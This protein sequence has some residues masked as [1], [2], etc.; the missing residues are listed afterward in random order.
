MSAVDISPVPNGLN[1]IT[2]DNGSGKTSLLEA[3]YYLP[4]GRSFRVSNSN[5]LI[6]HEMAQ[7]S[8]SS[9][10]LTAER[11]IPIGVERTKRGETQQRIAEQNANIAELA[12]FLPVRVINSQSHQLFESGPAYRRKYLDWGLFYQYTNFFHCWRSYER[13]LKQR[14]IIL[15]ENKPKAELKSWSDELIKH[16]LEFDALRRQYVT[17]LTPILA[18]LAGELLDISELEVCYLPGWDES[19]ELADLLTENVGLEYGH[20]YTQYGPHRADLDLRINGLSIKH[21]LSRGQQKLF[22]CAMIVA[23]GMLLF[24][25]INKELI[26]LIDDLPA[27]LDNH[28]KAKLINLLE[29]QGAQVFITAIEG[30]MINE[31]NDSV[32]SKRK[33]F[34]VEHGTIRQ[35]QG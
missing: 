7:F 6:K 11:H 22:I 9:Q 34:H 26:Y 5:K 17:A 3:I 14:N 4:H 35:V 31:I 8:I 20:G 27:E 16:G 2:G 21:F 24:Q 12:A 19:F 1:I 13:V 23:Q 32:A 28:S 25:N 33:V 29:K 18:Q 10:L 15:R 30:K